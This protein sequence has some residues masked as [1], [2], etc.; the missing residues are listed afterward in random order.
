MA[1]NNL[2]GTMVREG[3]ISFVRIDRE[4][5]IKTKAEKLKLQNVRNNHNREVRKLGY[6]PRKTFNPS[7][8]SL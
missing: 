4:V 2:I 6:D 1:H 5:F 3:L 8:T 7:G